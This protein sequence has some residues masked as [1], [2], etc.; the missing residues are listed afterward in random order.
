MKPIDSRMI[1]ETSSSH[2]KDW[3]KTARRKISTRIRISS[4][5]DMTI[6]RHGS[7]ETLAIQT[8]GMI[9]GY[10]PLLDGDGPNHGIKQRPIATASPC[11]LCG[12]ERRLTQATPINQKMRAGPLFM[13]GCSTRVRSL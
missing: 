10:I 5:V 2:R 7:T 6:I 11:A 1:S 3:S 9:V 4:P 13:G 8:V 12:A